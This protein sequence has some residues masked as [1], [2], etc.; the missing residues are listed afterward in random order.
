MGAAADRAAILRPIP[1]IVGSFGPPTSGGIGVRSRSRRTSSLLE[2]CPHA[3]P[4]RRGRRVLVLDTD[5][6]GS[7][8]TWADLACELGTTI[9]TVVAMGAGLH[10]PGQ[11]P[12]VAA[13]YNVVV[14]ECPTRLDAAQRAVLIVCDLVVIPSGPST[15]ETWALAESLATVRRAQQLRPGARRAGAHHHHQEATRHRRR[16]RGTRCHRADGPRGP[17]RRTRVPGR[18]PGGG[19][20]RARQHDL[21]GPRATPPPRCGR[22]STSWRTCAHGRVEEAHRERA[23][24]DGCEDGRGDRPARPTRSSAARRQRLRRRTTL[25]HNALRRREGRA[26]AT[27]PARR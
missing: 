9:P 3:M 4:Q 20:G 8:P 7:A 27:A 21:R 23:L 1:P 16:A 5:P 12:A 26:R 2:P 25:L 24:A 15:F 14:I 18:V 22:W 11:L 19:G 17:A 13:D 10:Q 6:Q